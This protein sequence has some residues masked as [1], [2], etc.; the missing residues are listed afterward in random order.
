MKAKAP[1]APPT[2]S[3]Y[4]VGIDLG[5]TNSVVAFV[6]TAA[7]Q[8]AVQ[9]LAL[10]QLIAAG[11]VEARPVLPSFLYLPADG[12]LPANALKLPWPS[13]ADVVVGEFAHKRGIEVPARLIASAK[14]WL[15]HTGADRTAPILPW[16]STDDVRKMSPV[17]ASAQYLMH[18][19][20]AWDA[21]FA[22][23][24]LEQQDVLLTVPASFDAVARELTVQAARD[25]GLPHVTVLEEPQAAFYAWI[26]AHGDAWRQEVRVGDIVLVCDIGGGTTDFSL[27]AVRDEGGGLLL[28]RV[29]VG[30][31][32]LLGGDNMD[33][34]LAYSVR[35]RLAQG[36][37]ALDAWQF[38]SLSLSCREAKERLLSGGKDTKH[39][40]AILGRGRKVVGGSVR[41]DIE[42]DEV[43]RTLVDGFF[44][45]CDIGDRPQAQRR[46]ALQ[47]IGLPYASDPAVTR[48]LAYF[49]SRQ[50]GA[51]AGSGPAAQPT[52]IL[53]NGGVMRAAGLR[54]RLLDVTNT[55]FGATP[56]VL[57]G[58]D[59]EHAVARGAAYYGLA[60]RGRGVRIRGGTARAY[61]IGIETAMPAVPGHRPPIKALCVVPHGLEE[62]SEVDL[63]AQEFGL[64]VGEPA[65]FRFLG[66]AT[67]RDDR[68]GTLVETWDDDI[69][70]L[71]PLETTLDW[72]GQEGTTVPV[73]L[74]ARVTEV[75]V[76][77]LWCVSRDGTHRWKLEFNVRST[78]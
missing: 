48:H 43:E 54:E 29:A 23:A 3:R 39:P 42:H 45:R 24:P 30:D 77:E 12:E 49:L 58:G 76:L 70:E 61:Y 74:Q 47:E 41:V 1:A 69:Q 31:H 25:A 53:F 33:L 73:R 62:G 16:A 18:M 40:V 37:T 8:P 38:R 68:V 2:T 13:P 19:R 60:R 52:A 15:S 72:K 14:S 66:S 51:V 6:D 26:D 27:I 35:D 63:P 64:I 75:G 44:P 7:E 55:W 56:R 28:E 71:A 10:P 4:I 22:D 59:P 50:S 34:T 32:I 67:R 36:G 11:S 46:T 20:H 21:A 65:E 5:T 57:G 17:A 9:V 78:P